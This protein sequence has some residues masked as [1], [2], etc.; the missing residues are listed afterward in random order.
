MFSQSIIKVSRASVKYLQV[1]ASAVTDRHASNAMLY[2]SKLLNPGYYKTQ[3]SRMAG[4]PALR[5]FPS[6][7]QANSGLLATKYVV[8]GKKH[9]STYSFSNSL[10]HG[11]AFEE[12]I[13]PN[14]FLIPLEDS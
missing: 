1:K 2:G 4:P 13:P 12:G 8:L 14:S 3:Y 5:A 6:A 10:Q 11:L 9:V 7:R